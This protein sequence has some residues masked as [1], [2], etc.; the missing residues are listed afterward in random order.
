MA[1]GKKRANGSLVALGT[2]SGTSFDG[3]DAAIIETDGEEVSVFGAM[4]G[5]SYTREERATLR[6]AL[7]EA[8]ALTDR[9]ARPGVLA[10]AERLI[11]EAHSEA[12]LTLIRRA[13]LKPG[14]IDVVGFHGQTVLHA[15][16][17][18]LT[19]Q[20]GRGARMAELTGI[21]TVWDFRAADVAAGGQGAPIAPIYHK[22]LVRQS[23]LEW[24]VAVVNIG[25][26]ANITWMDGDG[27]LMAFDCGPGNAMLDD[28][29]VTRTGEPM[30]EGGRIAAK[31]AVDEDIL[32]AYLTHPFFEAPYPKSLDRYAFSADKVRELG[33]ED[34]AATLMAFTAEGIARSV[35]HMP[36]APKRIIVS[37]GGARNPTLLRE[38]AARSA[39]AVET[40]GDHN[41]SEEFIE[42]QAFAYLAV[43]SLKG[44]PLTFPGTT[45]V[46]EPLTGGKLAKAGA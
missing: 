22:A 44:L 2:M 17:H 28:L 31:G 13:G 26:V 8:R 29:M 36:A 43:R 25:G 33:L 46:K 38:L 35:A 16:R 27:G 30:D 18:H 37:G 42:G 9:D 32:N 39:I 21:D 19:V 11:E 34:A 40:A 5:R 7:E 45:G 6:A 12:I 20:I 4:L 14:D 10:E 23:G 41:W 15:P 1:L 24:P 3:V